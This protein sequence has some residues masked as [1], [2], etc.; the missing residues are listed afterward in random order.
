MD[1]PK[2]PPIVFANRVLRQ[3]VDHMIDEQMVILP[4][5]FTVLRTTFRSYKGSWEQLTL[6]DIQ[7]MR[8]LSRIEGLGQDA[9]PGHADGA[10][11]MPEI[12]RTR[13]VIVFA[14]GDTIPAVV[15]P[16]MIAAGWE[17][18]R[19][20]QWYDTGNDEIAVDFTD[21]LGHGFM[22]KGSDEDSDDYVATTRNQVAYQFGTMCF[23]GWLVATRTFERFTLASGRTV[24]IV[25]T[26]ND[27]LLFSLGGQFTNEDEWTVSADGRAPNENVVGVVVQPP[28]SV[29]EDFFTLQLRL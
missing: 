5:D 21:G 19:A 12:F 20:V 25:Y 15:S 9:G 2:K 24:P 23:G 18:G 8:L 22:L 1:A 13:D 17:G 7:Q 4:R 6:G 27:S 28:S 16:A 3:F 26:P 14:K 29:T 10:G 11:L